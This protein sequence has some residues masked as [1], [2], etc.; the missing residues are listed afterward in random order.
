MDS[1]NVS[2]ILDVQAAVGIGSRK[3]LDDV[4]AG[5]VDTKDKIIGASRLLTR[6][7]SYQAPAGPL[8]FGV[9][10]IEDGPQVGRVW[11]VLHLSIHGTI[12]LGGIPDPFTAVA[13]PAIAFVAD[14][15][16]QDSATE[17][18]FTDIIAKFA[19]CDGTPQF[20][21]SRRGALLRWP[22][23][24]VFITKGAVANTLLIASVQ[25]V[26]HDMNRYLQN[27]SGG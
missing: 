9:C 23:R 3:S 4:M 26:D 10:T 17:P 20:V 24:I 12:T 13:I 18:P 27:F 14:T 5:R 25:V 8:T 2:G 6:K 22:Q 21:P 16:F 7:G 19:N 11:E 1:K 15:N